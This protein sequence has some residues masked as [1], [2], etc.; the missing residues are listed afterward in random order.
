M[1]KKRPVRFLEQENFEL[2]KTE[3]ELARQ[4]VA[5]DVDKVE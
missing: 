2:H 4:H 5:V 3:A 1:S